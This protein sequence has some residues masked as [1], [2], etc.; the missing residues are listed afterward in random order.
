MSTTGDGIRI[1]PNPA[2]NKEKATIEKNSKKSESEKKILRSRFSVDDDELLKADISVV[3]EGEI[4]EG[5]T[6]S[7]DSRVYRTSNGKEQL[8]VDLG[9]G[10]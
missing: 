6:R 4:I 10:I 8:D 1:N 5:T 2:T 7:K 9:N 3:D